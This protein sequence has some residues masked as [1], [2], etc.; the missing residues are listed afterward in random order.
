MDSGDTIRVPEAG[1]IRRQGS[2][3]GNLFIKIKVQL[4][5]LP[6]ISIKLT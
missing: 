6:C 2:Q 5:L 4:L 3:P 1:N